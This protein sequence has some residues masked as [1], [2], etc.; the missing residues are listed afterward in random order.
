MSDKLL[1]SLQKAVESLEKDRDTQRQQIENLT[2]EVGELKGEVEELKG[3]VEV[4][5]LL[6]AISLPRLESIIFNILVRVASNHIFWASL[7]ER[8]LSVK[9]VKKREMELA[10]E[11]TQS[12]TSNE[13]LEEVGRKIVE[14]LEKKRAWSVQKSEERRQFERT[15]NYNSR[16]PVIN[17]VNQLQAESLPGQL[18]TKDDIEFIYQEY[19]KIVHWRSHSSRKVTTRELSSILTH[20]SDKGETAI[21]RRMK[22]LYRII[23]GFA[24]DEIPAGSEEVEIE[25]DGSDYGGETMVA[26]G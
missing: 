20:L 1:A 5:K 7:E 2:G 22:Q 24:Y 16:L 19:I 13:K 21:V 11:R 9:E 10:W 6:T 8:W 15:Y 23:F 3:E 18:I 14:R 25:N 17:V 26:S 4:L 12:R